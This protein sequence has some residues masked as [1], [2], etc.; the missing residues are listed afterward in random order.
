LISSVSVVSVAVTIGSGGQKEQLG[1]PLDERM[2][3]NF[4]AG[5]TQLSSR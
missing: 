3:P 1:F 4:T 2:S 5:T